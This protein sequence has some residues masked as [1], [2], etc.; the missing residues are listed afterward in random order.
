MNK[1]NLSTCIQ[2]KI[3]LSKWKQSE[4]KNKNKQ[5]TGQKKYAKQQ[6]RTIYGDDF[7]LLQY[8]PSSRLV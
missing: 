5:G 8:N 1:L 6:N 7:F 4:I 2:Q 3:Y